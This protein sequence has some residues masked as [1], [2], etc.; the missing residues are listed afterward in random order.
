M[1][2]V[3]KTTVVFRITKMSNAHGGIYNISTVGSE[4]DDLCYPLIP[5]RVLA[6]IKSS[7]KDAF[8]TETRSI[9]FEEE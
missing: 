7:I 6:G 8:E 5:A 9:V 2:N 1:E 4:L 3:E